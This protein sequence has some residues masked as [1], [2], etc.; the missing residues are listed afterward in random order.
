M[1]KSIL[2]YFFLLFSLMAVLIHP[3]LEYYFSVYMDATITMDMIEGYSQDLKTYKEFV[4]V[5]PTNKEGLMA[6]VTK[7]EEVDSPKW[8]LPYLWR[9][10]A[11]KDKW[12][13]NFIY[14]Y[15]K[16]D[17]IPKIYSAGADGI[18]SSDGNDEDDI[19]S[20]DRKQKW[21]K[22]YYEKREEKEN[23]IKLLNWLLI[24][25]IIFI[26]YKLLKLSNNRLENTEWTEKFICPLLVIIGFA[27]LLYIVPNY[28]VYNSS[29]F[30]LLGD[31]LPLTIASA[32]LVWFGFI[33]LKVISVLAKIFYAL[34]TAITTY[35][36]IYNLAGVLWTWNVF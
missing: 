32:I 10:N 18:S 31:A 33:G 17:K 1:K 7:Y 8:R 9:K 27:C 20:W 5:Y 12:G 35:L 2:I 16:N 15:D 30:N 19:N 29:F 4:G 36:L 11:P 34:L 26:N 24:I 22:Y 25:P 14:H 3:K 6:L 13:N 28:A 21:R 23:F